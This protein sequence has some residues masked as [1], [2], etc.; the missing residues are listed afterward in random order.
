ML[1]YQLQPYY[2]QRNLTGHLSVASPLES[3]KIT[4]KQTF[5]FFNVYFQMISKVLQHPPADT[6]TRRETAATEATRYSFHP[7]SQLRSQP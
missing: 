1:I 2:L 3:I 6:Q 5:N 7:H 4:F